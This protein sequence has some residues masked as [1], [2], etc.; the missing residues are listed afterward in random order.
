VDVIDGARGGTVGWGTALQAG[1]SR[2]RFPVVSLE[3]FIDIILPATRRFWGSTQPLKFVIL[4][5]LC[6]LFGVCGLLLL[7]DTGVHWS[8]SQVR[9]IY[10]TQSH[11]HTIYHTHTLSHSHTR[12]LTLT[13]SHTH[14]HILTLT[15]SYTYTHTLSLLPQNRS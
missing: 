11:T 12:T 1:R 9:L 8:L 13:L 3:F 10:F 6:A 14:T 15:H 2:A 4:C 7:L 5:N